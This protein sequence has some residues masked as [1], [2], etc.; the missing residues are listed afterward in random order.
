VPIGT[1]LFDA[2]WRLLCDLDHVGQRYVAAK[3]G[4]AR[5]AICIS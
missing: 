4:A 2:E 1:Q 5:G 3:G